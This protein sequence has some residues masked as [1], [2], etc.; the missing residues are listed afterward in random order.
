MPA[1]I[2]AVAFDLGGTL[3][4]IYYDEAT[5]LE[6]TRGLQEL[7]IKSGLDPGLVL[8]DLKAAILS[9]MDAYKAWR[10][11]SLIEL[12]P[13][14]VWTEYIFPRH[15]LPSDRLAAVA[16]DLT[17]YYEN[18]FMTRT[19]RPEAPRVLAALRDQ[20]FRLAVISNVISRRQVRY[21]LTAYGLEHYF[22]PIITSAGVGY[23]KP[24]PHIFL[25]ASRW[26]GLPPRAC[27][28]V[29]DTASRDVV[30]ARRAGYGLAI[31]I[32]SFLTD[33]SDRGMEIEP[34]D[35]V[36]SDLTEVIPLVTSWHMV[37]AHD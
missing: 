3:E 16:E 14:R 10:E 1:A 4:N 11:E 17:L 13:E 25:E 33:S 20:G 36:V 18:H 24:H 2:Q 32:K 22:D 28:Y 37:R 27:A 19:L 8:P 23:R 26:M 29:G 34:P 7:L 9:G 35:A 5:R 30:G 31:Q 12:P 21:N 6:A 15:G